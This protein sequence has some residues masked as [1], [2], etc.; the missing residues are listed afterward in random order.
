[1]STENHKTKVLYVITKSNFGGAQKYVY[2]LATSLPQDSFDVAVALGGDG[3]LITK[4]REA[5]IRIIPISSLTRDVNPLGD[6]KTFLTLLEIFKKENPRVVHLNS[7]KI[8]IMGGIAGRLA[9][10]P[11][12]IFTAHGWAFNENRP[13]VSRILIKFLSWITVLIVHKTIAVSDAIARDMRWP[14]T[15]RKMVT[16]KNG[17]R[18]IEFFPRDEARTLLNARVSTQIPSTAFVFGTIAE[19]HPS[20]GLTYAIKAFAKVSSKNPHIYYIILGGGQDHILL[21]ELI[22]TLNL[23]ER[24]FLLGFVDN[25]PQYL[26]AFDCFILPSTTEALGLVLLEAGLAGIPTIG[27]NVG[28]IPEVIEDERTGLLVPPKNAE[29]LM[30]GLFQILESPTVR[31]G[32]GNALHQKVLES[33]S[34]ETTLSATVDLYNKN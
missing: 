2:D 19:L 28:G 34:F 29:A 9:R 11:K 23:E 14:F 18:P 31:T 4:L 5:G 22:K 3:I 20:K 25:A 21:Q 16:I 27:T 12:I 1:M 7:S 6:F 8:G 17:I 33:F 15:S 26:K 24:V 32:L 10:I 30:L 13:L